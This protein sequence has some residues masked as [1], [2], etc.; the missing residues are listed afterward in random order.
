[1][2]RDIIPFYEIADKSRGKNHWRIIINQTEKN[3]RIVTRFRGTKREVKLEA[4]R[5]YDERSE[6][7]IQKGDI[8]LKKYVDILSKEK[9]ILVNKN[10]IDP[11]DSSRTYISFGPQS[12]RA[13]S[14]D[15]RR[16]LSVLGSVKLKQV[17]QTHVD[18]LWEFYIDQEYSSRSIY[19]YLLHLKG[20]LMRAVED[21]KISVIPKFP[22]EKDIKK[23]R[24]VKPDK[25]NRAKNTNS[26]KGEVGFGV[27]TINRQDEVSGYD[28]LNRFLQEIKK[29][30]PD[31]YEEGYEKLR[32]D[33][34]SYHKKL[35]GSSF[36][37]IV[38]PF[39]FHQ[40]WEENNFNYFEQF[41]IYFQL[42]ITWGF[43]PSE[44]RA[45][46][47]KHIDLDQRE[48]SIIET[49][50]KGLSGDSD[51]FLKPHNKNYHIREIPMDES[52]Y[53]MLLNYHDW[54]SDYIKHVVT[55]RSLQEKD[56]WKGYIAKVDKR[57]SSSFYDKKAKMF[58][59]RTKLNPNVPPI[60]SSAE[61]DLLLFYDFNG[62]F[63]NRLNL[64]TIKDIIWN[65][66]G[67]K[68]LP[69][70][71]FPQLYSSS[72]RSF[73]TNN[74]TGDG[75]FKNAMPVPL[76]MKVVGHKNIKTTMTY[77]NP[78]KDTIREAQLKARKKIN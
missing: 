32:K 26:K 68:R 52:D 12:Y 42:L 30:D 33:N 57:Y 24:L 63:L 66:I 16:F 49:V 59:P 6:F 62:N 78:D 75:D 1:M 21:G 53:Q 20:V 9:N 17:D 23:G 39:Y 2:P 54:H 10:R 28:E 67:K 64:Y 15:M 3:E 73:L 70:G 55:N 50:T 25:S 44:G 40:Q 31:Y 37:T 29:L 60:E 13:W 72:R 14:R 38:T 46:A 36:Q 35:M 8:T 69:N 41:K 51:S 56:I 27:G 58:R 47:W 7:F 77:V 61:K 74:A 76:L 19:R 11:T 43:R 65:N 48:F 18:L 71:R 4:K 45:L 22:M 5:L 34:N